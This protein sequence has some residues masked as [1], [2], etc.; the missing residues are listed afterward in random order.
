MTSLSPD[1][2][3]KL[4]KSDA[5]MVRSIL[6]PRGGAMNRLLFQLP[7]TTWD[8]FWRTGSASVGIAGLPPASQELARQA[9]GS[10]RVTSSSGDSYRP[11]D[12]VTQGRLQLQIGGTLDRPTIW[13]SMRFGNHGVDHN[14]LYAEGFSR[15]PPA[16]RR[17]QARTRPTTVPKAPAFRRKVTLRDR[18]RKTAGDG[19]R[20]TGAR[21]L[22][23]YLR[24]LST[25]VNLP[26]VAECAYK[27][28]EQDPDQKWLRE[29]WWLSA[30]IV[31]RPLAEALDLLCVDFEYE[32]RY[33]DGL[34]LLRPYRWFADPAEQGYRY[35]K[36]GPAS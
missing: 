18:P 12:L 30:D 3:Q 35:P 8:Q 9:A 15:Q 26:I 32:W 14:L 31:D 7:P 11:A 20:P 24:D 34:L 17:R 6:H 4:R 28:R 23:E 33:Q 2:L 22:A 5:N 27:N 1:E 36:P 19:E 29:Q 10:S 16:D 21:P 25:Q 13:A